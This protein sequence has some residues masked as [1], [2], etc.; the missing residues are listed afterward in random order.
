MTLSE[1]TISIGSWLQRVLK[2]YSPPASMDRETL[3]DELNLIVNDINSY[4]PSNFNPNDINA[5]L[6]KTDVHVRAYQAS[7]S[8]PT[9]KTFIESTKKA[10]DEYARNTLIASDQPVAM[11]SNQAS[12]VKRIKNGHDIPDWLLAEDCPYR[13][14]LLAETDLQES[15]FNKYIDPTA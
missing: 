2:R 10:V 1:R 8:W 3:G 11:V 7:R 6:E 12:M 15:D 5:V 13:E 14:Q 9:I 4:I